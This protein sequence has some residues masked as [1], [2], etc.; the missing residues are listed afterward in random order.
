MRNS[1]LALAVS[2]VFLL[3]FTAEA[4]TFDFSVSALG[5]SVSG[6]LT[7]T[8]NNDGSFLVTS[9][10]GT[11]IGGLIT[12]GDPFFGNDNLI[13]PGNTRSVDVDGLAFTGDIAGQMYSI[14]VFST[15]SGFEVLGLD[16][17]DNVYF[18]PATFSLTN[19]ASA[20][21]EP[22]SLLLLGTGLLGAGGT[23]FRR[24]TA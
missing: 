5:S 8:N 14:D 23:A 6:V 17:S 11:E 2:S 1:L 9:V 16:S 19:A 13:F 12:A 18:E 24:R 20:T 3:P 15:V 7:A 4:D 22:S 10:T 21:P